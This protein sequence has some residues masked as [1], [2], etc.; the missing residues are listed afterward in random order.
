MGWAL[1][2]YRRRMRKSDRETFLGAKNLRAGAAVGDGVKQGTTEALR[3]ER[4]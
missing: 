3:R 4:R 1:R 2:V